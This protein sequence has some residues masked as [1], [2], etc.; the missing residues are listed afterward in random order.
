M[1]LVSGPDEKLYFSI[2]GLGAHWQRNRCNPN[3][4]PVVPSAED[5]AAEDWST[6]A[7]TI[8]RLNLDGSILMTTPPSTG[9][10]ATCSRRWM[11]CPV[12]PT[13]AGESRHLANPGAIIEFRYDGAP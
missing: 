10:E 9:S 1:S 7:G 12:G 4:A 11:G 3:L 5:V 2:G 8:L 6:Y 13:D